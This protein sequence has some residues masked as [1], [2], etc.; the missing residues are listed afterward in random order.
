[1]AAR[2]SQDDDDECPGSCYFMHSMSFDDR[3]VVIHYIWFQAGL[4]YWMPLAVEYGQRLELLL[5]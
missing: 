3:K 5:N 2:T 4:P 1:M